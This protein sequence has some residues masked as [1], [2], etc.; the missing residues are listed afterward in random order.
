MS[1]PLPYHDKETPSGMDDSYSLLVGPDGFECFLGEPEDRV[2]WRDGE[3]AVIRLNE[4]HATIAALTTQVAALRDALTIMRDRFTGGASERYDELAER[5]Y[6]ATG[7]M[8]PGKSVPAEFATN[9][10]HEQRSKRWD[11]WCAEDWCALMLKVNAALSHPPA[12]EGK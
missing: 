4:Q 11:E 12:G 2:W 1:D 3:S 7:M 10:T 8:A 5:F 6:R 9:W